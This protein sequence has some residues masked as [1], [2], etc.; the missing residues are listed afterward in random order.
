MYYN[1]KPKSVPKG[2]TIMCFHLPK[3][4]FGLMFIGNPNF[5][6]LTFKIS[7]PNYNDL[8]IKIGDLD[9]IDLTIKVDGPGCD[10]LATRIGG[11][12]SDDLTIKN[13][14]FGFY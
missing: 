13:W 10:N 9:S 2:V 14:W 4:I 6:D 5:D 12:S 3:V 1:T 7:S 8:A 11:P